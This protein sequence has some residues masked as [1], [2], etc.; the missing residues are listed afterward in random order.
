MPSSPRFC[1]R[2]INSNAEKRINGPVP[3]P[4]LPAVRHA[5]VEFMA[6]SFGVSEQGVRISRFHVVPMQY[7]FLA[8]SFP[9]PCVPTD[10]RQN[11]FTLDRSF[12]PCLRKFEQS[13]PVSFPFA[14]G[15]PHGPYLHIPDRVCLDVAIRLGILRPIDSRCLYRIAHRM[16]E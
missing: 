4:T 13:L 3:Q 7:T 10:W 9:P 5:I 16:R 1:P 2:G 12:G 11:A 6:Y 15:R 8:C 14:L